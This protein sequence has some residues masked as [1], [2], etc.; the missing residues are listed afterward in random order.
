VAVERGVET[1][2]PDREAGTDGPLGPGRFA[3][4]REPV[5]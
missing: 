3:T 1:F 5:E 2:D 4:F